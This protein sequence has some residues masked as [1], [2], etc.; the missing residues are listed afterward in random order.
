MVKYFLRLCNILNSKLMQN[1][2]K[3]DKMLNSYRNLYYISYL[4]RIKSD[5]KILYII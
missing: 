4:I 1:D 2:K 3:I 5:N